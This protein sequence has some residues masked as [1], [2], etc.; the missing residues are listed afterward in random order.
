ML[1]VMETEYIC[2]TNGTVYC[3]ISQL[4]PP[5]S[6]TDP[7]RVTFG[8]RRSPFRRRQHSLGTR[9]VGACQTQGRTSNPWSRFGMS[10]LKMAI[11]ERRTHRHITNTWL[12][13]NTAPGLPS[14]TNT[15]TN[16]APGLPSL[17]EVQMPSSVGQQLVKLP[18]SSSSAFKAW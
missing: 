4:H 9:V 2:R 11:R 1:M 17:P 18:F 13:T 16:T 8:L 12:N 15:D 5:E 14:N 7:G 3:Q 6:L 10:S